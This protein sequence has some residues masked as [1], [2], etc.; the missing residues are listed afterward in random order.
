MGWLSNRQREL[1]AQFLEPNPELNNHKGLETLRLSFYTSEM[2]AVSQIV[3]QVQDVVKGTF[4]QGAKDEKTKERYRNTLANLGLVTDD[5]RPTPLAHAVLDVV[6]ARG[7]TAA[8]LPSSGSELSDAIDP[9]IFRGV[10]DR[11]LDGEETKATRAI[12]PLLGSVRLL[13]DAIPTAEL[14]TVADDLDLLFFLQSIHSIGH[15]IGRF[16]RLSKTVRDETVAEWKSAVASFPDTQ[17]TSDVVERTAWTYLRPV[18]KKTL[19]ADC[20]NRVHSLVGAYLAAQAELGERFPYVDRHGHM[21]R[22]VAVGP[23]RSKAAN[24]YVLPPASSTPV[25]KPRQRLVSGCPGAG[26]SYVLQEDAKSVGNDALVFRTTF[27]SETSYFDFVGCYKPVPVY[28]QGGAA[29]HDASGVAFPHGKPVIDYR[30]VPG[31]LV[32]ALLFAVLNPT[33]TVVLIIE[34]LNRDA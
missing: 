22:A 18:A 6:A 27:H 2:K 4:G 28:E 14:A 19:Q 21:V 3:T 5:D 29:L 34:E 26:K 11:L 12:L 17:P 8:T 20:R 23:P 33:R 24:A 30:Y 9:V 1:F 15:E 16:F 32:R 13:V 10:L 31:P 7:W 25:A